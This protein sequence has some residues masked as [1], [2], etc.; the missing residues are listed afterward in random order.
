MGYVPEGVE[1][2]V[3]MV[4]VVEHV[5]LQLV[6]EKEAVA[7]EGSPEAEKETG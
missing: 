2:K 7:P 6:G 3:A 1:P 4:K 5:G